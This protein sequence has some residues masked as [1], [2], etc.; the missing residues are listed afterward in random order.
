MKI[1]LV[2]DKLFHAEGRAEKWKDGQTDMAKLKVGFLKFANAPKNDS[3]LH[4][5]T[6]THTHKYIYIYIYV[7]I[8]LHETV[9]H[10]MQHL[11]DCIHCH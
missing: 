7:R 10:N 3:H 1:C 11:L 9:H 5:H 6:H 4:T 8:Y 2:G